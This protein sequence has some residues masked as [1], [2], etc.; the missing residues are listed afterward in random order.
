M[1]P[2]FVSLSKD[3]RFTV[4][5]SG[6]EQSGGTTIFM[7]NL[8]KNEIIAKFEGHSQKLQNL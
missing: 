8:I 2:H 6:D 4:E 7:R 1:L 3:D 5:A